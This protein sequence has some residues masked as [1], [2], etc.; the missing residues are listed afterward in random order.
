[1]VAEKPALHLVWF[2]DVVYVKPIPE[3]LLNWDFWKGWIAHCAGICPAGRVEGGKKWCPLPVACGFLRSY[4]RLIRH[5]SDFRIAVEIGLVPDSISWPSFCRFIAQFSRISDSHISDRYHYGQLRLTR[6]NWA[7]RLARPRSAKGMWNYYGVYWQTG[8]YVQ[9]L[10]GP[11]MFGFVSMATI[12]SAMQVV[13]S[14]PDGKAMFPR[15][16]NAFVGV[17]WEFCVIVIALVIVLWIVLLGGISCVISAQILFSVRQIRRK[18][19][20]QER[21]SALLCQIS[22]NC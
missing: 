20:E 9:R 14:I 17:S 3:C 19:A 5:Y 10:L 16:W 18:D 2:Y 4:S 13:I 11:L 8:Q 21:R 1:V 6:L 22:E 12:L 15:G 7:V